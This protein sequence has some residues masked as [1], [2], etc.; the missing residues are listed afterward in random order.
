MGEAAG[1]AACMS[2][3]NDVTPRNVDVSALQRELVAN[4]VNLGQSMRKIP[5]LE[6]ADDAEDE[7]ANPEYIK[8]A[9]TIKGAGNEFTR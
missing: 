6:M 3:D 5:S 7:Y 8:N 9:V 4:N 2:I 1:T